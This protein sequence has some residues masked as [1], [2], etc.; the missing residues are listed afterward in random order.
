[1]SLG[2]QRHIGSEFLPAY[3]ISG[4][5]YI[6]R[7]EKD[8]PTTDP[9]YVSPNKFVV[10]FPYV[11]SWI[12]IRSLSTSGS[13]ITKLSF[14]EDGLSNGQHLVFDQAFFSATT[15]ENAD[16]TLRV[17]C[18]EIFIETAGSGGAE[19]G[20]E[21]E[22]LAGLTNIPAENFNFDMSTLH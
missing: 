9:S 10:K 20:S 1:M 6:K 2:N 8:I 12:Y 3:Q 16:P 19:D 5:P 15:M 21:V 7:L 17:R 18:K 11:T 13:S 4:L 14:T 22:V